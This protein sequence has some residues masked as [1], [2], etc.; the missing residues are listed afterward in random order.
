MKWEV[1]NIE[2]AT[3]ECLSNAHRLCPP[4]GSS[5]H[6]DGEEGNR[7]HVTESYRCVCDCHHVGTHVYEI[8]RDNPAGKKVI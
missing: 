5:I 6:I 7:Y 3:K 8:T 1:R 4:L 2:I